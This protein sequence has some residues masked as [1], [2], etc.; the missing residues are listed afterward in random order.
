[1]DKLEK[2][3]KKLGIETVKEMEAMDTSA[4]E[5]SIVSAEQA[6]KQVKE[7]LEA[8]PQFQHLKDN[9][10]ALSLGKREVDARQ[11]AKIQL[12]LHFL[13]DKGK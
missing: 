10:K 4:L 6:M 1:M 3:V 13:S 9:L 7:E 2:L 5:S 11:K 8:N 12:A